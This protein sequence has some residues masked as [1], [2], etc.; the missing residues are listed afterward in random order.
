M[1]ATGVPGS[2]A[3][4][5]V[6]ANNRTVMITQDVQPMRS[7]VRKA[8][9]V[10]FPCIKCAP[11]HSFLRIPLLPLLAYAVGSDA[12]YCVSTRT[13]S[14]EREWQISRHLWKIPGSFHL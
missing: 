7:P 3:A 1:L 11:C 10:T 8:S 13:V 9:V 14:G 5:S 4:R 6:R 2:L 12:E